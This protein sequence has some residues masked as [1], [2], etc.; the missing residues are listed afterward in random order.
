MGDLGGEHGRGRQHLLF[1]ADFGVAAAP[2]TQTPTTPSTPVTA[3]KGLCILKADD[4]EDNRSVMR[5]CLKQS[6]IRARFGGRRR[7]RPGK[8]E[9]RQVRLGV[10][11]CPHA[12]HGWIRCH[13]CPSRIRTGSEPSC[14]ACLGVWRQSPDTHRNPPRCCRPRR[15]STSELAANLVS[16]SN[17]SRVSVCMALPAW[18]GQLDDLSQNGRG[19]DNGSVVAIFTTWRSPRKQAQS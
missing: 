15:H 3:S 10:D 1:T 8:A 6:P 11:R 13:A 17:P 2:A 16:H 12:A 14:V 19:F 4:S 5:A 18:P 7:L 9:N